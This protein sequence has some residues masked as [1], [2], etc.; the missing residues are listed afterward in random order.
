MGGTVCGASP[1]WDFGDCLVGRCLSVSVAA[2]LSLAA[3]SVPSP[4]ASSAAAKDRVVAGRTATHAGLSAEAREAIRRTIEKTILNEDAKLTA[5]DAAAG[6]QFGQSVAVSGNI[7]VIGSYLEDRPNCTDCGAAYV[8]ERPS[9]GWSGPL[10][11]TAK[12]T[13]SDAADGDWFGQAVS[14]S[15]DIVVVGAP[16]PSCVTSDSDNC[17]AVYVFE[18]AAGGWSSATETAKLIASDAEAF[19]GYGVSVS[20]SEDTVVVGAYLTDRSRCPDCGSAYVFEKPIGGWS[21]TLTEAAHLTASERTIRDFFGWSVSISGGT[22][23]VGA[24]ET[25][26]AQGGGCGSVYLYQKPL[27]G[28]SGP[29]TENAKL[30][31]SD[32]YAGHLLGRSVSILGDTVVAGAFGH[33][34]Q[35]GRFCGAAYVFR[36]PTGGWSETLTETAMLTAS[37]AADEDLFGWSV[38]VSEDTVVVGAVSDDCAAGTSCGSAYIFEKPS[39]GWA[40]AHEDSKV[41]AVD[42]VAF[43]LLGWSVAVSRDAIVAGAPLDDCPAGLFC[44]SA[45]VFDLNSPPVADAGPDQNLDA[46]GPGGLAVTLDGSGSMDP[47]ADPLTYMWSGPFG[48]ASGVSPAVRIPGGVHT[49]TLKVDDGRGGMD[50]DTVTI[51]VRTI[52][53]SPSSLTFTVEKGSVAKGARGLSQPFTV[54]AL[55]GTVPYSIARTASWLDS[56][57]AGG[58]SS[59]EADTIVALADPGKLPPGAHTARLVVNGPGVIKQSLQATLIVT[60]AG[61]GGPPTP[62][63]FENGVVDTADFTP[64][65]QPGH[66]TALQSMVSIFGEDFVAAGEFQAESIPLP[67]MLGG[68]MVTFDGIKAPLFLVSPGLIIAQL[69]AGVT[70][71]TATMVIT[72]GG[73]KA[74]STPIEI[75]VAPHSPGVFTL[76]QDGQGQAI[77]VHAGTADLAAPVGA[78]GNSRPAGEGDHLTIYMNG[79][80][81]LDPPLPDGHNSCEPNGVCLPDGPNVVLHHTLTKPIIRIGGIEVP[82]ENVLFSGASPASVAVNEVVF[83][84]PAGVPA[85]DAVSLT[86]EIGGVLSNET[87]IAVK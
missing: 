14:I 83:T 72:N 21:G 49:V 54:R 73:A 10:T 70:L 19:D 69:P 28:W 46:P 37:D 42:P 58:E 61:G 78:V 30:T 5:S 84:M 25:D 53:V 68:V 81:P 60:G 52:V 7:V 32:A 41:T 9:R 40:D 43:A 1:G 4:A 76:T 22:V 50:T 86:V 87:T 48:T 12:L 35:A 29:V 15:G 8:F 67:T 24:F 51:T 66:A 47:D 17:G 20:V 64:F 57:P 75:Q 36:K 55:G 45:Y 44:G 63:P 6:D 23:V 59:G 62:K 80:G 31:A 18:R 39:E 38:S 56:S 26:C 11:Q 2:V 16:G 85:G 27:G 3:F 79:L 74:A 13:A 65:G 34:C 82:E 77:V 71:P 33:D